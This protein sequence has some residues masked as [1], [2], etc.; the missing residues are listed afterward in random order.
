M[1][2]EHI[3]ALFREWGSASGSSVLVEEGRV[4]TEG[5]RI[6]R[7]HYQRERVGWIVQEKKRRFREEHGSLYCEV[8][9]TD[10]QS[11]YGALWSERAIEAH[12]IQPLSEEE[13]RRPTRLEDLLLVCS[14]CHRLIH[15][16]KD[17]VVNLNSLLRIFGKEPIVDSKT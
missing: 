8:C 3:A 12:H 15:Q 9:E 13:T 5:R 17:V 1:S 6:L 14:T 4:A 11:R 2:E 16:S 7:V 10:F